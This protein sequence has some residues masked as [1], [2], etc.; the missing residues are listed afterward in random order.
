MTIPE[1]Y[2]NLCRKDFRDPAT[3]SLFF[4]VYIYLYQPEKEYEIRAE[5]ASLSERLKRPADFI[6]AMTLDVFD[7]FISFL[8]EES[9]GEQ[10]LLETYLEEE[11]KNNRG[12]EEL[13]KNK[14]NSDAFM[15]YLDKK[16]KGY[17]HLPSKLEKVYVFIYGVGKIYPWLR[18][19]RFLNK[20]EKYIHGYKMIIFYPGEAKDHFSLFG[21]LNDENAYRSIK[22]INDN[23]FNI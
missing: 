8:K 12:I 15:K 20:F 23:T 13:I 7:E 1:L 16:I 2:T 9:F 19:S 11:S 5:I 3:G 21:K 6:D 4:P 10:N 17:L 22:L 18:V 14:A